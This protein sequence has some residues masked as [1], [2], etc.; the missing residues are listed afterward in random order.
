MLCGF[1]LW[2]CSQGLWN[3]CDCCLREGG[4]P[5]ALIRRSTCLLNYC[6]LW[7]EGRAEQQQMDQVP[8]DRFDKHL[9]E[10]S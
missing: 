2:D 9:T 4:L 8:D 6:V 10:K 7:R 1:F 5:R 3:Y